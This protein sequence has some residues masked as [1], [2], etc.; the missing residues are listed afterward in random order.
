LRNNKDRAEAH[1]RLMSTVGFAN[2]QTPVLSNKVTPAG[3]FLSL[4]LSLSLHKPPYLIRLICT[5]T[6]KHRPL[7]GTFSEIVGLAWTP[8]ILIL[9]FRITVKN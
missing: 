1:K 6:N 9:L 5:L 4:S 2:E 8:Q 7:P 3:F